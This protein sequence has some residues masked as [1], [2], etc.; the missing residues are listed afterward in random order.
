MTNI[1]AICPSRPAETVS[2][3]RGRDADGRMPEP[4]D[5]TA[6]VV[7]RNGRDVRIERGGHISTARVAFGCI[8]QPEPGDRV[9]TAIADGTIWVTA[10]LERPSDA[11]CVCGP[12]ATLSICSLR[13][14]VSVPPP[15]SFTVDAAQRVRLAAPEIDL[16]AGI[17]RF[18]LDELV[19]VGRRASLLVGKIRC[20]GE[21]VE[22]FADHVLT[23]AKRSSG[24][25]KT[26]IRFAPAT[27]I[28]APRARLQMRAEIHVH[29]GRHRCAGG[30]RPDP[31][32]LSRHTGRGSA[33][34]RIRR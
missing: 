32:G 19:Q 20:V 3:G 22:T 31:H 26:A 29:D 18:V 33:C 11:P 16:H 7:A 6:M 17:A 25:S 2:F 23:R 1:S 8:V 28:I 24:L 15:K 30:C 12:R 13:G 5:H 34:S 21:M 4:P 27:S 9:L 10:V 14:N